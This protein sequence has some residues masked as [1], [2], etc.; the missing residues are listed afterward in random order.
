M[1]Y[2]VTTTLIRT[3]SHLATSKVTTEKLTHHQPFHHQEVESLP[4]KLWTKLVY[5]IGNSVLPCSLEVQVYTWWHNWKYNANLLGCTYSTQ[6]YG[7]LHDLWGFLTRSSLPSEMGKDNT[8]F[9]SF[10]R[11]SP[12]QAW[13]LHNSLKR[14]N[15][16]IL[17][18]ASVEKYKQN[19]LFL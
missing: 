19:I 18:D 4:A 17:N 2:C 16:K 9:A 14:K 6:E 3:Y 5:L 8:C 13:V 10:L 15:T 7:F 11:A 1:S 12:E